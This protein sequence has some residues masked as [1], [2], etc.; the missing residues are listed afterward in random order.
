MGKF[1]EEVYKRRLHS[2]LGYLPPVEFEAQYV[3]RAGS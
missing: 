3:L 2:S 1:I